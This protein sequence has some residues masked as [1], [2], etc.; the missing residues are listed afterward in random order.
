MKYK[1]IPTF[2]T[3]LDNELN[4]KNLQNIAGAGC[5]NDRQSEKNSDMAKK[6]LPYTFRLFD[7]N[8]N[9]EKRWYI[10]YYDDANKRIRL[11]DGLNNT[12][13]V[14]NRR[15]IADMLIN[16]L[17]RKYT[18]RAD[19][20]VSLEISLLNRSVSERTK[21]DYKSKLRIF[22]SFCQENNI[23][24]MNA[25]SAILFPAYLRKWGLS[26]TTINDHIILLRSGFKSMIA[27][28]KWKDANP[29]LAVE[30][31]KA[32]A[33]PAKYFTK[34]QI[35]EL[36]P[37]MMKDRELWF[38]VELIYYCYIRPNEIRHLKVSDINLDD[39]IITIPSEIAKNRKQASVVIPS[40][41]M[42]SV[43]AWLRGRK[44]SEWLFPSSRTAHA[45]ICRNHMIRKHQAVL[46][47]MGYDTDN[48]MLYS[49]K[50]TGA[51][52]A[53]KAK[54]SLKFL[55]IQLRHSSLDMVNKY[56]RQLGIIDMEDFSENM[57]AI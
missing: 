32:E 11:Y 5:A 4:I 52:M 13:S 43:E 31:F 41:F 55:Q 49:W 53:V 18:F 37:E 38:F 28:G 26:D 16:D 51:V 46:G 35:E 8:G 56:L 36:K 14:A 40:A 15:Q 9:T 21:G 6:N 17:K 42:P 10:E 30:F 39:C 33:K 7:S 19:W 34:R 24:V 47:Y 1:K 29:F 57:P 22:K 27:Q 50:H 3:T 20:L 23:Q 2:G 25:E 54:I 48:Y 44:N 45:P 12:A